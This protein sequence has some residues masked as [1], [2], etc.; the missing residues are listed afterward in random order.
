MNTNRNYAK[1]L[2]NPEAGTIVTTDL[3][4]AISIDLTAKM[5]A[6]INSLVAVLGITELEPVAAGSVLNIYKYSRKGDI[7]AQVGEGETIGLTEY[8]RKI[9][10]SITMTLNKFRKKTTAEAI[11]RVGRG[12]AVNDTD[13][14]LIRDVQKNVKTDFYSALTTGATTTT[15]TVAGLQGALAALWGDVNTYFADVDA[16]P[17]Y[18]VNPLDVADYLA[19]ATITTQ[20]AFGFKYV[21]DF[22]GLGTVI[23]DAAVAAGN[24]YATAKEN[25][26]GA[27]VP[28]GG[29]VATAFGLT[30]DETGLVGMTHYITGE[31]ASLETLVLEGVALYTEDASGVFKA[32]IG[33]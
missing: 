18:F 19:N 1:Q 7:P 23:L 26:R 2:F 21:E 32:A 13:N 6:G 20:T 5:I 4:P 3:D 17:V 31:N 33:E 12:K 28:A 29:D 24:V 14:M 10:K 15:P 22:L 25:V 30:Y 11:Q 27:F 16:T 9:V 8:Q